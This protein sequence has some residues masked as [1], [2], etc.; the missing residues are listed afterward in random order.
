MA[1]HLGLGQ[2]RQ[3]DRAFAAE[4]AE[5]VGHIEG[6]GQIDARAGVGALLEQER[7][8]DDQATIAGNGADRRGGG[9]MDLV[10]RR[11]SVSA[12]TRASISCSLLVSVAA[13]SN[14]FSSSGYDG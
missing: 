5:T 10:H 14:R 1:H 8:L 3:A 11:T 13:S 7:F 12:A 4:L 6:F 9:H 2:A